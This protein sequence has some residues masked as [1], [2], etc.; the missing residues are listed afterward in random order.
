MAAVVL[1]TATDVSAAQWEQIQQSL[2]PIPVLHYAEGVP[3][4]TAFKARQTA[5]WD[6]MARGPKKP[7]C[8][9]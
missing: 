5:A 1:A 9:S 3:A 7:R 2:W 6:A 4:L 8:G